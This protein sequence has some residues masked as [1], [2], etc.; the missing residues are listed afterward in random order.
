MPQIKQLADD[1]KDEPV[2]I[3]GMNSDENVADAQTVIDVFKLPLYPTLKNAVDG[4]TTQAASRIQYSI[5]GFPTL[6]LIDQQGIVRHFHV[7][8]HADAAR[9]YDARI[10]QF[11]SHR[12]DAT[13]QT[14]ARSGNSS[15][16]QSGGR[17]KCPAAGCGLSS[18]AA[19]NAAVPLLPMASW[20][21]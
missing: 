11:F 10:R 15:L 19:G 21:R 13:G 16:D 3:L 2:A 20:L 17:K 8:L 6:V 7:W 14:V 12:P 18:F 4:N 5:Q 9:R 1:F